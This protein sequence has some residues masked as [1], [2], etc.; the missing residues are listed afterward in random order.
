MLADGG[1]ALPVEDGID[2]RELPVRRRVLGQDAV[3]AA[4]EMQVLHFVA[5]LGQRGEAGSDVE[6][7]VAEEAVLRDVE[8][9]SRPPPDCRAP[10]SKS[11]LLIA[12]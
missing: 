12:E 1:L 2:Q 8:R 5:D 7:H 11:M 3:A 10:I 6:V 9:G 4:A